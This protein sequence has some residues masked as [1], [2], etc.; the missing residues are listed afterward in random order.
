MN[1]DN[2][3]VVVTG[4]G[5]GLGQQL[6]LQLLDKG[7]SIAAIDINEQALGETREL[8]GHRAAKLSVHVADITDRDRVKELPGEIAGFHHC[9]D[10]LINN[11]GVIQPFVTFAE[12]DVEHIRRV[13]DINCYGMV[14]MCQAF[15]PYL[16]DRPE[17]YIANVSSMG[18]LLPVPGQTF[19]GASKAAAK[20]LTEGM[21][22]ELSK[23]Q[24][25]VSVIIPGG[26]ETNIKEHSHADSGRA[27]SEERK[28]AGIT[29]TTPECAARIIVRGIEKEKARILIGKDALIMDFLSRMLPLQAGKLLGKAM[30]ENHGDI[31]NQTTSLQKLSRQES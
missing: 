12:M 23:T 25:G 27:A 18:G 10:V 8:A 21:R 13:F 19:Y 11:A 1:F 16:A 7:A 5:A 29:L 28:S 15:I 9:I 20:L 30:S 24:I 17:A 6:V 26:L 14:H 4:A 31:F 2:K 22:I 3:V